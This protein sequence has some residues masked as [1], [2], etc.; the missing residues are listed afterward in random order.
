MSEERL[1][2]DW[3]KT[4]KDCHGDPGGHDPNDHFVQQAIDILTTRGAFASEEA[5]K[6]F[7]DGNYFEAW[8]AER[9][10]S[11]IYH[12]LFHAM[13]TYYGDTMYCVAAQ[14]SH[15]FK[16]NVVGYTINDPKFKTRGSLLM[17]CEN[18]RKHWKEEMPWILSKKLVSAK[19]SGTS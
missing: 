3:A 4:W 8:W 17:Q 16:N 12:I 18:C 7:R 19:S 6:H 13:R 10:R 15:P 14:N 1:F 9:R 11:R 5:D 2:R